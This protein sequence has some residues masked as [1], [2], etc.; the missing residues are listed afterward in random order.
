MR[1][2][3]IFISDAGF[4]FKKLLENIEG[5]NP[6]VLYT[7]IEAVGNSALVQGARLLV[8]ESG[9][10][11]GTLGMEMLDGEAVRRAEE[12]FMR[13]V[14]RT[15]IFEL[16]LPGLEKVAV[17]EDSYFPEKRLV[18]FGGGHIALP[19]V[20]MASI[21][22]YQTVVIDD[23]PEF[24][25]RERFPAAE[26]VI[27]AGFSDVLSDEFL[28]DRIDAATSVVI[29][30]R[31]HRYDKE[32]L[33]AV[34]RY[35]ARYVG[36]IGSKNKVRQIFRELLD[37][38]ADRAALERVSA[39]IGLDLGGQRPPEIALSILAEMVARENNGT[40]RP[41]KEVKGGVLG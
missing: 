41:M 35:P 38:G 26:E 30:T 7:L 33:A 24:A 20:E 10:K 29:I 11:Y 16:N 2:G 19:L 37:G 5:G 9:E 1:E 40:C 39:P 23:R 8:C 25:S 18:V 17:L 3:G 31:G 12:I 27:C 21:L 34:L 32:C 22:G 28:A 14:P 13:S 6:A 36:M 4:I 15:D